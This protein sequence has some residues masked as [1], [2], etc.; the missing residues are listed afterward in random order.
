MNDNEARDKAA[1]EYVGDINQP[2]LYR[3]EIAFRRGWDAK[4]AHDAEKVKGLVEALKFYADRA[5]WGNGQ[6][7]IDPCDTY[8]CELGVMRGGIRAIDALKEWEKYRG[9]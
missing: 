2:P 3:E 1:Q 9:T 8:P 7:A 6:A 4:A 5:V